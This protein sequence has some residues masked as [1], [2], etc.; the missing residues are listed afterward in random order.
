ML[1]TLKI[2]DLFVLHRRRQGKSQGPCQKLEQIIAERRYPSACRVM[3][4]NAL[5]F[6]R[7]LIHLR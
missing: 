1:H 5:I 6:P 7:V 4:S 2:D 3:R